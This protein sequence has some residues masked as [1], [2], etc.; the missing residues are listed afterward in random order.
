MNHRGLSMKVSRRQIVKAR[1]SRTSQVRAAVLIAL[2]YIE[3]ELNRLL[4][5]IEFNSSLRW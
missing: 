5:R 4:D 2:A 3:R 1:A